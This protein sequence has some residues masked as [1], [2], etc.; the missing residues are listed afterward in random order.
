MS[1]YILTFEKPLKDIEEKISSLKNTANK[2]GVDVSHQIITLKKELISRSQE[3]YKNLSRWERVQLAR[4]PKRPNTMDY[5]NVITDNWFELHGDRCFGDDPAIISGIGKIENKSVFLIGH[6]KGKGTKDKL[7]RNFGMPK[8]EGYRKAYR[9]MQLAE[10]FSIPVITF[11]DTPGAYPGLG[12]EQRGQAEAIAKNIYKMSFLKVP[13]LSIVIGE[14]ASGGALGIGVCDRLLCLE[15]TWYS[16]ISPEGCASI[17]YHDSTKAEDAADSMK[18]TSLDLLKMGIAD[19]I[20]DEP[21][22]GAHNDLLT[23]GELVKQSILEFIK[24]YEIKSIDELIN[25][26]VKKYD[27]MGNWDE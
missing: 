21:T 26:R 16:V 6:Q 9:I 15:N 4:H 12:A 8:P 7:K 18:V 10:K 11:L 25:D 1:K 3:I 20:I 24:E 19:G 17:L 13:I 22:G 23:T 2:A 14:G 5:I 27:K